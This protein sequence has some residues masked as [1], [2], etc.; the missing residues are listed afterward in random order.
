MDKQLFLILFDNSKLED[1]DALH[2]T[3]TLNPR[4][5][6]WFHY[7]NSMYIVYSDYSI[8]D[9]QNVV[10]PHLGDSNSIIMPFDPGEGWYGLLPDNAW[11]WL[12]KYGFGRSTVT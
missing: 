5:I 1:Y 10:T 3:L 11:D 8:I 7:I 12:E 2:R 4:I 6:D 9:V